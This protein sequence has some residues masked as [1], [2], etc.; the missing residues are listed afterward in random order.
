MITNGLEKR[1]RD[2]GFT[3]DVRRA[4][5]MSEVTSF[6]IG[7]PADCILYPHGLEDLQILLALFREEGMG[8][9]LLGNGTNLLASDGGVHEP[10]INLSHGFAEIRRQGT[11]VMV[12]AGLGL[13]H[14][15]RFCAANGLS[16]LEPLAGIPGTVGGG[17]RMNAGSWGAEI[18][19]RISSL[20]VMGRAGAIRWVK[21]EEITF[22]YRGIDL[23]AE[24]IILQGELSL[25]Q[26]E[27]SEITGRMKDF[28]HRRKE[29]QPLFQPSAGSI[30]KNPEGQPAGKLIEEVGLKGI[31]RG[32]AM[33]SP[34]H[35]NFIVNVGAAQARDVLGLIELIRERV[36]QEKGTMLELEVQ[37]IGEP[38][39]AQ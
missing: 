15:L 11:K 27:V 9:L 25:H 18:G 37:I 32:D 26:G 21:R 3:G 4:V 24:E 23:P 31:R 6:R 36:Y 33:V 7:G 17:I 29:T 38:E 12:G 2:N 8:Y 13:L 39:V 34:L 30:F 28:M 19:D 1:I 35:A 5:P 10:L 14:V 16:G 22:G 20:M